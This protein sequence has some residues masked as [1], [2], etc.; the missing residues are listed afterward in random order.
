MLLSAC[1]GLRSI[2]SPEYWSGIGSESGLSAEPPQSCSSFTHRLAQV[3]SWVGLL[4]IGQAEG[5]VELG[6]EHV[7]VHQAV[8]LWVE[9][10]RDQ[11]GILVAESR[12]RSCC[13]GDGPTV[14]MV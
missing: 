10:L 8:G 14:A 9:T 1:Q 11:E 12:Q 3:P 2:L 4:I 5:G 6:V 7:V 13:D